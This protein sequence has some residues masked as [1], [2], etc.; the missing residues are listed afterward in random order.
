MTLRGVE[1]VF[2]GKTWLIDWLRS[3]EGLHFQVFVRR[4]LC[5]SSCTVSTE[6]SQEALTALQAARSGV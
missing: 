1:F 3:F 2:G 6:S 4:G 5:R